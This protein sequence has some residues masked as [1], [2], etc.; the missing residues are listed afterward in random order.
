MITFQ[1]ISWYSSQNQSDLFIYWFSNSIHWFSDLVTAIKGI[2]HP[3]HTVWSESFKLWK[4]N[5]HMHRAHKIWKTETQMCLLDTQEW[6]KLVPVCQALMLS[7]YLP[8]LMCSICVLINVNEYFLSHILLLLVLFAL[9][10]QRVFFCSL[11]GST[12]AYARVI[13]MGQRRRVWNKKCCFRDLT[14]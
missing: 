13:L 5:S 14:T 12:V 2:V 3:V 1:C 7:F 11:N 4:F 10:Y 9:L 8:C 6:S